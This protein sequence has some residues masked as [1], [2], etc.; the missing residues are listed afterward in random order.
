MPKIKVPISGGFYRS[1]SQPLSNQDAINVYPQLPQTKYALNKG[2]LFRTPGILKT[3]SVGLGSNR[4]LHK[5][6]KTNTLYQVSGNDLISQ[7]SLIGPTVLGTIAGSGQVSMADNGLVVC[8]IVPGGNGY[9]YTVATGVLSQITDPVFADFQ[10]QPG[11]VTSVTEQSNR[12]VYTTSEEFFLGSTVETNDGKDFDALDFEDA[13]VS[14]DPIVRAMVVNNELYMFGSET[15]EIYSNQGGSDFPYIRISGATIDKGIKSRF[16]VVEVNGAF[17]FLG[18]GINEAPGIWQTGR[19]NAI[20]VSTS[21]IDSVIQDYTDEELSSV[22]AWSYSQDSNIFTGFTF[23]DRTFVYDSVASVVGGV[24]V[25]HERK[26]DDSRWRV[27]DMVNIF[28]VTIVSDYED[29]R[30]GILDRKYTDEYEVLVDRT[31]TVPYV[32]TNSNSFRISSAELSCTRGQGVDTDPLANDPMIEM[33]TSTNQ[34]NTYNSLG[35]RSLG[36]EGEFDKRQ[37]WRRLGRAPYSM[38][39]RFKTNAPIKVDFQRLDLEIKG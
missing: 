27:E 33:L 26:T 39:F 25:W 18:N 14:S 1:E 28:G 37:I 31:F 36:K 13:E 11:G 32:F 23:P 19:G 5:F 8:I 29:G 7:T 2:A 3:N 30:M 6:Q 34:A 4:A 10:A 9:F 12:F 35:E 22:K 24:P 20:K 16:G 38:V 15:T 21:A 17:L